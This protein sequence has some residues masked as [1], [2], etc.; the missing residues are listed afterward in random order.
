[1]RSDVD[2]RKHVQGRK[3]K[4]HAIRNSSMFSCKVVFRYAVSAGSKYFRNILR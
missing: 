4:A 3:V 2:K 1:M